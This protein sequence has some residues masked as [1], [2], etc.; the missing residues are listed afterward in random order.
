MISFSIFSQSDENINYDY[1]SNVELRT[2]EK[3]NNFLKDDFYK[4]DNEAAE[5]TESL[6]QKLWSWVYKLFRFIESGGKP[7]SYSFYA[8][9]VLLLIIAIS[10]L[11]GIKY[12][13]LFLKSLKISEA[14]FVVF[15]EDIYS[16]NFD[17]EINEAVKQENYR[18]AVRFLYIKFLKVLADNELIEWEINKTNKDYRKEMKKTKYDSIF[19]SLTLVYEYVWYGEFE[20]N[21]T[22]YGKY[23][24]DYKK[25][26]K[27]FK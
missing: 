13:S 16:I 3:I 17:Q 15:D 8:V 7:V 2:S 27:D 22:Q 14:D 10:K 9:L 6:W 20:S 23:F 25:V 21:K 12:K 26:F 11:L 4:Y 1:H 24:N 5:A 19:K 18:K